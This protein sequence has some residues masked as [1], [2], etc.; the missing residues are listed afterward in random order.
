MFSGPA[1]KTRTMLPVADLMEVA[2]RNQL[3]SIVDGNPGDCFTHDLVRQ[4]AYPDV[5]RAGA[6]LRRSSNAA[7]TRLHLQ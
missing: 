5:P 2:K 3:S 1:C 6:E 7:S 4:P